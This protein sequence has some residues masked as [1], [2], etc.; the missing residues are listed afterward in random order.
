MLMS[1]EMKPVQIKVKHVIRVVI[2]L[3]FAL[4][5][6]LYGI[7]LFH[8]PKYR[9]MP[10]HEIESIYKK[11]KD[12]EGKMY[13][14]EGSL[15]FKKR[16]FYLDGKPFRIF[17]G[18]FHYFRVLPQYWNETFMKMKAC[19]L[20]TVETY[21]AWNFHEEVQG[22]FNFVGNYKLLNVRE[23]IQ[24]AKSYGLY[25]IL[26]P[27]PYICSEWEFGGL[28]SWLLKDDD[29]KVRSNYEG[30]LTAVDKYFAHL[31]P[32]I[33]DLQYGKGG[34]IIAFQIEN[35]FASY[36]T[37]VNH[38]KTLKKMMKKH[39]VV[40]MFFTSDSEISSWKHGLHSIVYEALPTV[41]FKDL[42]AG[43]QQLMDFVQGLSDEFPL[44]VME[45][46]SGWFDEWGRP[47]S[48]DLPTE[49]LKEILTKLLEKGA[50]I[51]FYMFRGGTNFGFMNGGNYL[52]KQYSPVTTSYDYMAPLSEAGDVTEKYHIIRELL[53]QHQDDVQH[54]HGATL[55]EIPRNTEKAAYGTVPIKSYLPFENMLDEIKGKI[56]SKN[57]YSMEHLTLHHGGGQNYGFI[58]YR[59]I[60]PKIQKLEIKGIMQDRMQ[61]FWNGKE[62]AT[63]DWNEN[64]Y[65]IHMD[66]VGPVRMDEKHNTLDLLVENLGRVNY[67]RFGKDSLNQ[68][69]KGI[70]GEVFVNNSKE[71]LTDWN[72]YPLD[73][74]PQ[75]LNNIWVN[76]GY[77]PLVKREASPAIFS[78][79]FDIQGTPKDTFLS[80]DGWSKGV[81][82]IN[83]FNLGRYWSQGPQ[84]TLYVPGSILKNEK[85]NTIRIFEQKKAGKEVIFVDSPVLGG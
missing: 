84:R 55:K 24:T 19:G 83:H 49:R 14:S 76:S 33:Q 78:A 73:F 31:I 2:I 68:E 74:Q 43:G 64:V 21:V 52:H 75:Y 28:P 4:I 34:P 59:K 82:F 47:H 65:V 20:N 25:V 32:H 7:P 11:V 54:F 42:D 58:L 29:M 36:S 35:E 53:L 85:A 67:V 27:G 80:M 23:F 77:R 51:N 57:I 18:A 45:Y 12:E 56:G 66:L 72:I 8:R 46:W 17:S 63:Y 70:I 79:E 44:F 71:A 26:R 39:G 9:Q 62:V 10:Q 41:N 81:V 61:V 1:E 5:I 37:E 15:K 69:Y 30:Y 13:R 48:G 6:I 22:Q 40:E 38:L 50:S 3:V 16:K 60:L